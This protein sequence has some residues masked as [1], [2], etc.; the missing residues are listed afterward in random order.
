MKGFTQRLGRGLIALALLLS[1]ASLAADGMTVIDS[2]Y[3]V[4]ETEQRLVEAIEAKGMGV[5]AQIDHRANASSVGLDMR[6]TR[7]VIFGNPKGGTQLMQCAPTVAID[8]P[9]KMLIWQEGE[10]VRIGYNQ[11]EYLVAR[12]GIG[13]C[14]APVQTKMKQVLAGLAQTAAGD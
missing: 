6:P 4:A 14:A 12:H 9:M 1:G 3:G 10:T 11:A 2:Q 13:D 7:L 8:L 5:M